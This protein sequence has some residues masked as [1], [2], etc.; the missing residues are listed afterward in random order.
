MLQETNDSLRKPFQFALGAMAK[1]HTLP[2]YK[3]Y[4]AWEFLGSIEG[5][6]PFSAAMV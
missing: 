3:G 1:P 6:L 4:N 5:K 2:N